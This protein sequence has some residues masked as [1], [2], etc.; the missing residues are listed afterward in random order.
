VIEVK[1]NCRG[2]D[3]NKAETKATVIQG[4]QGQRSPQYGV[5]CYKV[6]LEL[7]TIMGRFG[8]TYDSATNT[9]F[10]NAT[11]PNEAEANWRGIHY[12]N[13]DFFVSLEEDK[14]IFLRKYELSPGKFRFFRAVQS[15][16]I[17]ELFSMMRSLWIP[18]NQ[19]AQP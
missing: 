12:P 1:G 7:K 18:A 19:T 8:Y 10:D 11:V 5:V 14:K 4:L 16:L 3:L 15:P 2:S 9:F 17:K 6:A 13:L